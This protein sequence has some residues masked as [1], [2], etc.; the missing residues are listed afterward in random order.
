MR[1]LRT[2]GGDDVAIFGGGIIPEEDVAALK[3][4][5]VRELFTPGASTDDIVAWV[6]ANV[7][8]R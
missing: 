7:R 5:G 6:R 1:E 2:R 3:A 4:Q 8:P